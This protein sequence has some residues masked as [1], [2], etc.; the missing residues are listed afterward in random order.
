MESSTGRLE[1][2]VERCNARMRLSGRH[3][4]EEGLLATVTDDGKRLE[5]IK[6]QEH[7]HVARKR[8]Q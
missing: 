5:S 2:P 4:M 7:N 3:T 6:L 1:E 8:L